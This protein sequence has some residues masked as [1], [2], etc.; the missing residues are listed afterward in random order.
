MYKSIYHFVRTELLEYCV[1]FNSKAIGWANTVQLLVGHIFKCSG[2][3]ATQFQQFGS[4]ACWDNNVVVHISTPQSLA[5]LQAVMLVSIDNAWKCKHILPLSCI[6]DLLPL[7]WSLVYWYLNLN[8]SVSSGP[9][10]WLVE[11]STFTRPHREILVPPR[12][13]NNY[14]QGTNNYPLGYL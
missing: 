2:M 5:G 3:N 4:V 7:L 14:P 6:H 8:R 12:G 9:Y 1:N 10:Y 11:R 13:T